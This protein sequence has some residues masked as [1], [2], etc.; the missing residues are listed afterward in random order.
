M[1]E[2]SVEEKAKRYDDV[3]SKLE[4]F[5]AQGVN[6][7]I[8]RADVQDFFPELAEPE[9]ERIR[10]RLL[11]YFKSFTSETF[12]N[13]VPTNDAIAWLEKQGEHANF[14]NKIQIG[15]KVTRNEDGVLVNL[16]QLK[17]VAK[18]DEKQSEQKPADKVE[19]KFKVGDW[20][21]F[22]GLTL[23]IKEV[24]KGYYRTISKGGITNSY[25]WDIDNVARLWTIQDAK[26][27][28][29]LVDKYNNISIYKEIEG[30]C[31][32]S[33]IYLGC[34]NRL[35]GFNI[36]GSHMQ[37]NTKPATKEQRDLLF[38]KMKKAGYEWDADAKVLKKIEQK[39]SWSEEDEKML[40]CAIDMIEW[41]S[42]V[43]KSK[44]KLVS[45]WLKLLKDRV[46]S[47]NG[48]NPYKRIKPITA[49]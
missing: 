26:N 12:F 39:S 3:V 11:E 49:V 20:I 5:M 21:V 8:T 32:R 41:Y 30:V 38:Q 16:S 28:D 13:G 44:S 2:L 22:N 37:N 34:D 4:R 47:Q 43:N 33:Y 27:G 40:E 18:K 1:K 24:V 29:V 19:H 25:D 45:D 48:Y 42:V 36:G 9:D 46:Q 17:R 6:P 10:K 15:D 14:R 31:W 35:Y 23:Y 7:L